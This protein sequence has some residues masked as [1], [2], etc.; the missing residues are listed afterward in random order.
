MAT[1]IRVDGGF[2]DGVLDA[3]PG[4]DH[5][6]RATPGPTSDPNAARDVHRR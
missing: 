4:T 1:L 2:P 6:E 3:G 5:P